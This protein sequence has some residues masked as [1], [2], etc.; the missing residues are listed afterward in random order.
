[1]NQWYASQERLARGG[2]DSP[3]VEREAKRNAQN[4]LNQIHNPQRPEL[5]DL[6]KNPLLLNLLA[7]YHRSNP[8]VELPRQRAELYQD[9]VTLQLRKRPEARDVELP[10]SSL[11]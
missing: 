9:I 7:T 4:L 3:E 10:L 5:A 11:G 6:A 2:L 8:S 1:V